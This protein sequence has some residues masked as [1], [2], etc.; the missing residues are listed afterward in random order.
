MT[1]K[2]SFQHSLKLAE[3]QGDV[4]FVVAAAVAEGWYGHEMFLD[5]ANMESLVESIV[6]L[7]Y[8]LSEIIR[9]CRMAHDEPPAVRV[10]QTAANPRWRDINRLARELR[11]TDHAHGIRESRRRARSMYHT[12]SE[13]ETETLDAVLDQADTY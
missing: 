3:E 4:A 13:M 8:Y 1:P 12:L 7:I 2:E 11:R 9:S 10:S 6:D 5:R